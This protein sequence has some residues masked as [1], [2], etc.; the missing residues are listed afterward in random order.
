MDWNMSHSLVQ[1]GL[2]GLTHDGIKYQPTL[3]LKGF[4]AVGA[5]HILHDPDKPDLH[6]NRELFFLQ[7]TSSMA[8]L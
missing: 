6:E 1:D 4:V 7:Y 2:T 5:V 8:Y 3:A